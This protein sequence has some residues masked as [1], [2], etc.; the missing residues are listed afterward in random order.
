MPVWVIDRRS[1]DVPVVSALGP[2]VDYDSVAA[3]RLTASADVL[4]FSHGVHDLPGLLH[5]RGATIARLGHGLTALKK[6]RRPT[7]RSRRMTSRVDVAP[8]ASAFEREHK[9]SWGFDDHQ[10]PITGL[11]R[12]DLMMK[13]RRESPQRDEVLFALTWRDWI[14]PSTLR[15]SVYWQQ[16]SQLADG[17]WRSGEGALGDLRAALFLHPLVREA[18]TQGLQDLP[19]KP[20]LVT[21]GTQLPAALARAALLVT[22]YSSLAWDALYLGVPVIFF[23]FDRAQFVTHHG[24]YIDLGSRLFGPTAETVDELQTYIDDFLDNGDLEGYKDDQAAWASRA[25]AFTD[26]DNCRRV[27]QAIEHHVNRE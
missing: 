6:T 5:N 2:W 12:W 14:T 22:D 21:R 10:L 16:L 18:L 9:R 1:K 11:A 20:R 8:V 24:S 25:F 3:H 19:T 26:D 17:L 23:H 13:E 15:D 27:V 4:V 7:A